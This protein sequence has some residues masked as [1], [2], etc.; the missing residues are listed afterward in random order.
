MGQSFSYRLGIYRS[1]LGYDF[2]GKK[3][4][5]LKFFLVLELL[6]NWS[7][8]A[9]LSRN[10]RMSAK[11]TGGQQSITKGSLVGFGVQSVEQ[12][13]RGSVLCGVNL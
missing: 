5:R 3:Q 2:G 1:S 12:S 10:V 9:Y 13:T 4:A 7:S 8:Q 6:Q 11:L